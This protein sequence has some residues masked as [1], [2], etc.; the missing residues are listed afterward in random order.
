MG[1]W[2]VADRFHWLRV[3]VALAS[4]V[5]LLLSAKLWLSARWYPLTPVVASLPSIAPPVDLLLF[6]LL[7]LLAI[8]LVGSSSRWAILAW[9]GLAGLL[10][11]EDQSRWQ[12][13]IY[14]YAFMLAAL[15]LGPR[16]GSRREADPVTL[17]TCR[18]IVASLYVWS[19]LQKL[20]AGFALDVVPYL[21]GPLVARSP[22]ATLYA[23]GSLIA[24][25][26][27]GVGIGLLTRRYRHPSVLGA[28]LLHLAIMVALGPW[29][30]D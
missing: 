26:E 27:L 13:W 20:N 16:S 18:F 17:N 28:A 11:L 3:T 25:F 19:E 9:I 15:A 2:P 7:L 23:L 14:Q 8:V 24:V 5:G 29:G 4:L 1:R 21:G 12:P 6:G 22:A 30:R 10:C